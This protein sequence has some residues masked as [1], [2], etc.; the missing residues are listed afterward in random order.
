[1][2]PIFVKL[3]INDPRGADESYQFAPHFPETIRELNDSVE[4]RI[5]DHAPMT[6]HLPLTEPAKSVH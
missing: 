4:D 3:F 2:L 5:S 1:M 6:V